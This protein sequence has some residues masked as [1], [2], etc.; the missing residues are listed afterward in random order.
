M[1]RAELPES[2]DFHLFPAEMSAWNNYPRNTTTGDSPWGRIC[3]NGSSYSTAECKDW[4]VCGRYSPY[5][6]K[7]GNLA[8]PSLMQAQ[9]RSG[10]LHRL[11]AS[12]GIVSECRG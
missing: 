6:L 1:R 2:L 8:A 3:A 10:S 4:V 11:S 5:L 12:G 7:H 9:F